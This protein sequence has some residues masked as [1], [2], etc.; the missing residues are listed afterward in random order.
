MF[1]IS[2]N[3]IILL[4]VVLLC[5]L[6]GI[7]QVYTQFMG[8]SLNTT[9]NEFEK[10]LIEKGFKKSSKTSIFYG[11]DSETNTRCFVSLYC[12]NGRI[13]SVS[14]HYNSEKNDTLS[15]RRLFLKTFT[16]LEKKY[17]TP[18]DASEEEGPVDFS[19]QNHNVIFFD[20]RIQLHIGV[21]GEGSMSDLGK[22]DKR[23]VITETY[24]PLP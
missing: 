10:K 15:A 19:F 23:Y 16:K 24:Y 14:R 22:G 13:V 9:P 7:A 8:I 6:K 3:R 1:R 2:V 11:M 21:F 12:Q 5:P 4:I 18:V 20:W 17:G